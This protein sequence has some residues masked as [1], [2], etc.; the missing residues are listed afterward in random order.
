MESTLENFTSSSNRPLS[1]VECT[2]EEKRKC[3]QRGVEFELSGNKDGKIYL[4][5]NFAP[6]RPLLPIGEVSITFRKCRIIL[7]IE[8]GEI[9]LKDLGLKKSFKTKVSKDINKKTGMKNAKSGGFD[10]G[11]EAGLDSKVGVNK[12]KSE[13][14]EEMSS[15]G[16]SYKI[17]EYHILAG[18]TASNRI[19]ELEDKESELGLRGAP[20][21]DLILGVL[22]KTSEKCTIWA[23]IVADEKDVLMEGVRLFKGGINK[24][25]K[26]VRSKL[27]QKY[28]YQDAP[29][30]KY[31]SKQDFHLL[32]LNCKCFKVEDE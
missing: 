20:D 27:I 28:C 22:R 13:A 15:K 23:K 5:F 4:D 7:D 18:G 6:Y 29:E 31:R 21:E 9:A 16:E 11:L 3:V 12:T 17:E 24:S 19:W 26:F 8:G 32:F 10:M 25:N 2:C 30:K 14:S 1:F